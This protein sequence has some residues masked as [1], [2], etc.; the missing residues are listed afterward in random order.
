[1]KKIMFVTFLL[2]LMIAGVASAVSI[3][4][5]VI[6]QAV[7]GGTHEDDTLYVPELYLLTSGADVVGMYLYVSKTTDGA[8]PLNFACKILEVDYSQTTYN[9]VLDAETEG[10]G[11][12]ASLGLPASITTGDYIIITD[13]VPSTALV[14]QVIT[15]TFPATGVSDRAVFQFIADSLRKVR[16]DVITINNFVDTEVLG[17]L[18]AARQCSAYVADGTSEIDTT[19]E[20]VRGGVAVIQ[21]AVDTEIGTIDGIVDD[22]LEIGATP[23]LHGNYLRVVVNF[24]T[25]GW[26]EATPHELLA[27][28]GSVEF[29]MTAVCST[30]ITTTS[31]DSLHIFYSQAGKALSVLGDDVDAGESL[32]PWS[33]DPNAI[34]PDP[35]QAVTILNSGPMWHGMFHDISGS[36]TSWEYN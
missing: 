35:A 23:Y 15:G 8:S 29:W 6:S 18:T 20:N 2:S 32:F 7:T 25:S 27:V 31:T 33:W 13:V 26:N 4:P 5:I 34:V 24:A 11:N 21:A 36:A 10:A 30:N 16:S 14:R 12:D 28:T 3:G 17:A 19:L 9:I 1:M 22:L